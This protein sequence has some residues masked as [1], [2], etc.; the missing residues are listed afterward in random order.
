MRKWFPV[1]LLLTL[2]IGL[3]ILGGAVGYRI[4]HHLSRTRPWRVNDRV[5]DRIRKWRQCETLAGTFNLLHLPMQGVE[6]CYY[7]PPTDFHRITWIGRDMPVPFV[8][9][10]PRPGPMASGYI[11]SMH[12]RYNRELDRPKPVGVFRIFIVGASTAFGAGASSND[13]TIG[14]FL[15]RYLNQAAP[16]GVRFE[17]ITA[18][19]SAWTTTHER[20]L[21]ENRL[22]ELEPDLIISFSGHNDAHWGSSDFNIMWFRAYQDDYFFLLANSLLACNFGDEF[23][24]DPP[25]TGEPISIAQSVDRLIRNVTLAHHALQRHGTEYCFA[26]QPIMALTNK[27]LTERERRMSEY[28]D[29]RG[30]IGRYRHYDKALSKLQRP[31]FHYWNLTGV[32]DSRPATEDVFIDGCH[33]GD[34]GYDLIARELKTRLLPLIERR[35]GDRQFSRR[36]D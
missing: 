26:L 1:A 29:Q 13:T 3:P 17:V 33:F 7:D 27:P 34:R 8:G 10:A 28:V 19:T 11:N 14:G 18:A 36:A 20:I 35:L 6:R 24:A 25:G 21:I 15:E 12:F 23:P 4:A 16:G 2:V 32:F 31:R 5:A 22:V 30:L 9:F